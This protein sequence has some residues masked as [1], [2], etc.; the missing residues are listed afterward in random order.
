M[1]TCVTY[2]AN[3]FMP[4][5]QIQPVCKM[6]DYMLTCVA[7]M[8]MYSCLCGRYSMCSRMCDC[9]Q[10]HACVAE[11]AVPACLCG[12]FC[13]CMHACVADT[14]CVAAYGTACNRVQA[15]VADYV[16]A[17]MRVWQTMRCMCGRVCHC[18]PAYGAD[19]TCRLCDYMFGGYS[20]WSKFCARMHACVADTACVAEYAIHAYLCDILCKCIHAC[21]ADTTRVQNVRL[22]AYVCGNYANVFMLVWQI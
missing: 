14:T 17:C 7:I 5:W 4:V 10:L 21:V 9:M 3:V 15:C 11:N 13:N 8:Q 22:H 6:C 12:G 1:H 2:Y 16:I 20:L 19:P 18:V